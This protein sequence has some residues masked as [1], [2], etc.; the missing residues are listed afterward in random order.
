MAMIG[1]PALLKNN[2]GPHAKVVNHS[3]KT[4]HFPS[5]S[6]R[7]AIP[8]KK[9]SR[10]RC[11]EVSRLQSLKASCHKAYS[12]SIVAGGFEEMS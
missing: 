10:I 4:H 1:E 6:A 3:E 7:S 5:K 11:K 2:P 9:G 8:M 12:H